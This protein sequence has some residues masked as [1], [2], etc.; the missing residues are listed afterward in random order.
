MGAILFSKFYDRYNLNLRVYHT[1]L[2]AWVIQK[3]KSNTTE[4]HIDMRGNLGVALANLLKLAYILFHN[5][6]KLGQAHVLH[7]HILS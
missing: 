6:W 2:N 5:M 1:K 7:M 4:A 3:H